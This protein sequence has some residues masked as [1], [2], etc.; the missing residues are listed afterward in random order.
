MIADVGRKPRW[1]ELQDCYRF[2][3]EEVQHH[4]VEPDAKITAGQMPNVY[5]YRAAEWR[6]EE[7]AVPIV[8]LEV[9]H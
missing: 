3:M 4:L 2:W 1:I 8:V 7:V 6:S 5:C 9:C